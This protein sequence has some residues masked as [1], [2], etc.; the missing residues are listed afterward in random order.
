MVLSFS[1]SGSSCRA[2]KY[3]W[4]FTKTTALLTGGWGDLY[5]I[6]KQIKKKQGWATILFFLEKN[7]PDWSCNDWQAISCHKHSNVENKI[8]FVFHGRRPN[9]SLY[10]YSNISWTV[11]FGGWYHVNIQTRIHLIVTWMKTA[12]DSFST[13]PGHYQQL[14]TCEIEKYNNS[15]D[16]RPLSGAIL[17]Y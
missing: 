7:V 11:G 10:S 17:I 9:I 16:K 3:V 5:T 8:K 15:Y 4:I 2:V 12:K 13:C 1:N 6:V 14:C